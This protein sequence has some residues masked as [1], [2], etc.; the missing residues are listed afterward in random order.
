MSDMPPPIDPQEPTTPPPQF[1]A[2]PR[3]PEIPPYGSVEK[4]QALSDGYFGLNNV[5][6][7]NIVLSLASRVLPIQAE[8]P[9][10]ALT[11]LIGIVVVFFFLIGGLTFPF[12]RKIA[13]GKD[14]PAGYAV[15]A[16]VLMGLNSAL[17]CGIIGYIVM[18]QIASAEMKKY[19]LTFSLFG[20]KKKD[21]QARIAQMKG[22]MP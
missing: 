8:N 10:E 14:W 16:S 4:L 22:Q 9:K 2:Y 12:N 3:G 19:G 18:Q 20:L 11:L 5:F 21:V 6:V 1:A 17:C 7:L 13:I 15:L